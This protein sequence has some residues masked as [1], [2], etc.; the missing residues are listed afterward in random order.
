MFCLILHHRLR[1]AWVTPLSYPVENVKIL[2]C[3]EIEQNETITVND[4]FSNCQKK[5]NSIWDSLSLTILNSE[6]KNVSFEITKMYGDRQHKEIFMS[7]I[8]KPYCF[9]EDICDA[10]ESWTFVFSEQ[11]INAAIYLNGYRSVEDEADPDLFTRI[12]DEEEL[13]RRRKRNEFNI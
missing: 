8:D 5:W 10:M 13:A 9:D 3:G 2:F 12:K 11:N 6:N 1:S 7:S 4:K